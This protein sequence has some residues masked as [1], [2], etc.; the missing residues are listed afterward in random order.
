M[1]QLYQKE[2]HANA[3][4]KFLI[5]MLAMGL[6]SSVNGQ[7]TCT[8]QCCWVAFIWKKFGK[9]ATLNSAGCD[10]SIPGVTYSGSVVTQID[11][12]DQ[13]LI[14]SIPSE[15]SKLTSLQIL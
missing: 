5:G 11:W 12:S 6:I 10:N 15:I 7:A 1:T 4:S 2:I 13:G 8:T 9:T 14:N 3:P